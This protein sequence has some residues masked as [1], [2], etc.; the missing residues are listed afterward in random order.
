MSERNDFVVY[1]YAREGAD[2]FGNV[3]TYYY[4]GKGLPKRP[5]SNNRYVKKP[6][7]T[8][9]IH[10]L[11]KNLNEKTAYEYERKF[12]FL[13]G[14]ESSNPGWGVLLNSTE[15]GGGT[16][17]YK[18]TSDNLEKIS[19]KNHHRSIRRNWCHGVL[20]FVGDKT[21][22]EIADLYKDTGVK[23]SGLN[24]LCYGHLR[25]YK[26]WVLIPQEKIEGL[27]KNC[28]PREVFNEEYAKKVIQ[29]IRKEK[30]LSKSGSNNHGYK[31]KSWSHVEKG[32]VKNKSASDLVR[33]FQNTGCS[34]SGLSQ[35]SLN[36]INQ[37]KGWVIVDDELV[38]S[39][40]SVEELNEK[41]GPRYASERIEEFNLAN[42]NNPAYKRIGK[43]NPMFGKTGE[44]HPAF[45]I[46]RSEK[47]CKKISQRARA[48]FTRYNWYH[49]NHGKVDNVLCCELIE[50]FP[51]L[52]L[53]QGCLSLVAKGKRKQHKAWV[54]LG[55]S[56]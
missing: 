37:H 35:L 14:R 1:A 40:L 9:N 11:H 41:F 8:A 47:T 52:K 51:N 4:I 5:Y 32:F 46:K 23:F 42:K 10:I 56:V 30:S 53:S 54:C 15:G 16:S 43:L 33:M 26:G 24:A 49:P 39:S 48:R 2:R 27:D 20:G 28:N 44:K 17:G 3:G 12:I 13:Y 50:M 29:E 36:K 55:K 7:N 45:G 34:M 6:E 18:W 21:S 38:D 19:G 25:S 22:S 31:P